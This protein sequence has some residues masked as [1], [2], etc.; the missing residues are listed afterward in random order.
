MP[1]STK[2][3]GRRP[4]DYLCAFNSQIRRRSAAGSDVMGAFH[5]GN[6]TPGVFIAGTVSPPPRREGASRRRGEQIWVAE[7]GVLIRLLKK[8]GKAQRSAT[9]GA[10]VTDGKWNSELTPFGSAEPGYCEIKLN[11]TDA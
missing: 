3:F 11:P 4:C 7:S 9:T 6:L 2:C 8:G 10:E 5:E 1:M